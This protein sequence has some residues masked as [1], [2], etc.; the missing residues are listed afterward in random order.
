MLIRVSGYNAGVQEYLEEGTKAGREF[1][2]DELDHRLILDGDLDVTRLVYESLPDKGQSR[3][4]T[5]TLAFAEDHLS[6]DLLRDIT[7]EFKQFAMFAY[8]PDEFNFYAEAHLPLIKS[9][10]DRLTGE[11]VERKP[12]IH[13]VIPRKNLLS[14]NEANPLG[15]HDGN[16]KYLE[17]FQEYINQK[18]KLTSPRERIRADITDAASVLSRYK[19]D[20]FYGKNR[21]FKQALVK[22]VIERGIITRPGFY[23]LAAEHG[24]TRIRNQGKPGEYIAVKL[25]G[26][27]KFTNLKDTIFQDDF[28]VRRE[29][30]KPPLDEKVIQQR[31]LE[32][33]KRAKEIKYVSKAGPAFRKL[34]ASAS[35]EDQV[36]L[37]E[38]RE[39]QFYQTHG[40]HYD[41]I[42]PTKRPR[43]QQRSAPE[44][45][46]TDPSPSSAGLQDL[47]L[48]DVATDRQTGS[49]GL[50]EGTLLLPSDAHLH[51]GQSEPGG[52][53]GL[54]PPVPGRGRDGGQPGPSGR[55]GRREPAA[56]VPAAT[57]GAGASRT[58]P[59]RRRPA[60]R[61]G[62]TDYPIPGHLLD[63]RRVPT[64]ADIQA[65]GRRLFDPLK[66]ADGAGLKITVAAL[67]PPQAQQPSAEGIGKAGRRR[68]QAR[69]PTKIKP[70][71]RKTDNPLP[72]YARNPHRV[73]G[74][75]DIEARSRRLFAPFKRPVDSALKIKL[76]SVKALTRNRSASTVAAYFSRQAEHNQLHR[77]QRHALRRVDKQYFDIRRAV[78]SDPRLTRQD[79]T[80]LASVLSF[81][82]LKAREAIHH[83][84]HNQEVSLMGSAEIRK[85]ITEEKED[86]GF[87]IAGAK[88]PD[89]EGVRVRVKRIL[90]KMSRQL[91]PAVRSERERELNAKDLYTRKA[92]FSQ[93]VHYLDKQTNKTLFVDTGKVIAMRRTGITEAGVAVALQLAKERFGST[94]TI[95]GTAEFKKLVIEAAAKNGM[96]IHFTDKSMNESLTARRAELEIER[97]AQNIE[98][99]A[100]ADAL[101]G[102]EAAPAA[103][104]QDQSVPAQGTAANDPDDLVGRE[105]QWRADHQ[106]SEDDVR[107]SATVMGVRGEDHAMW[108]V[109]A[110]EASPESVAMIKAY[111]AN[112]SYRESFKDTLEGLYSQASSPADVELL[113]N[114][115]SF[116]VEAVNEIEGRPSTAAGVPAPAAPSN[117]KLIVG[118]LLEHGAAPYQHQADKQASYFVTVKTAAGERTVWGVG[119]ADAMQDAG[120][121]IGDQVRLEDHGSK[122][123]TVEVPAADG[124]T[125]EKTTYRRAWTAEGLGAEQ[126]VASTQ[127]SSTSTPMPDTPEQEQGMNID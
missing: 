81:E 93:N 47:S 107:G 126:E 113:D 127:A 91:D 12:H 20:D 119:L 59:G 6:E 27:A 4:T 18:Y 88:G 114:L 43:N 45:G 111:L 17:A 108:L 90:D 49:T 76:G 69:S 15:M 44:V 67:E 19:A 53:P 11:L 105:A 97:E 74:I 2:R 72:P 80:Q 87:S 39:S 70:G 85:L 104:A 26:D 54:R 36:R 98:P 48:G 120:F 68:K 77:A 84:Q 41:G 99:A 24:E 122:P 82:R 30:K 40:D 118:E 123:V 55:P 10:K 110:N 25:P 31:L 7:Q 109:G 23:A 106:L 100:A 9:V 89:P 73:P 50:G 83:P 64:I 75:A 101:N 96:D 71:V 22:Q 57:E 86:P 14:G 60:A 63:P 103:P 117:R 3:Y 13:I 95:N 21:D 112:D 16:V 65:R 58:K 94:L 28:I 42:Q 124:S 35:P 51:V 34:Y 8:Q 38:S 5:F 66:G 121:E 56:A 92:K 52:D 78:F 102:S 115:T 79:K 125:T 33:P 29:L 1:T 32:W 61:T 62:V 46:N 37:L 116:A